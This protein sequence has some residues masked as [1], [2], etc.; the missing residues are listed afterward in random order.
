[1]EI[2]DPLLT[3]E[4]EECGHEEQW[5]D[6]T[7]PDK[8]ELPISTGNLVH[9]SLA[10]DRSSVFNICLKLA[11]FIHGETNGHVLVDCFRVL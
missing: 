7:S 5:K 6:M 4:S 8:L 1:M 9:R 3:E 10:I 11:R 2:I